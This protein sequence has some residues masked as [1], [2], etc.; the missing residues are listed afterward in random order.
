MP[1]NGV[2]RRFDKRLFLWKCQKRHFWN[3]TSPSLDEHRM[4]ST[5]L[6]LSLIG[7]KST[8]KVREI[9]NFEYKSEN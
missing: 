4:G 2:F 6:N 8:K 7:C 3:I 5:F 1:K 9:N